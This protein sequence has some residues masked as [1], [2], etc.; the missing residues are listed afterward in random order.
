M[1][2]G[3]IDIQIQIQFIVVQPKGHVTV[4]IYM[5]NKDNPLRAIV[6]NVWGLISTNSVSVLKPN[7]P[8]RV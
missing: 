6:P 5:N 1:R 2:E 3:N 8:H 4:A 7:Y